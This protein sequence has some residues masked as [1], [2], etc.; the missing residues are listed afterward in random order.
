MAK[1]KLNDIKSSRGSTNWE[2]VRQ[3]TDEEIQKAAS[4]SPDSK[5]LTEYEISELRRENSEK[6]A[7]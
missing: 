3:Q 4:T 2:V 5:L 6:G 7:E 1:I